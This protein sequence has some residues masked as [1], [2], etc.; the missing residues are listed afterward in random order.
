VK[1]NPDKSTGE[2]ARNVSERESIVPPL[3]RWQ[4][5]I[6]K[7][8][9]SML[10]VEY[11]RLEDYPQLLSAFQRI[12]TSLND[13]RTDLNL[14]PLTFSTSDVRLIPSE[15]FNAHHY[16]S[17]YGENG[18]FFDP[19][20]GVCYVRF[21]REVL[22][23]RR[24]EI[25]LMYVVAHELSHKAMKG[26]V[27][28]YSFHLDEGIADT[29]ARHVM[30]TSIYPQFLTEADYQNRESFVSGFQ[31]SVEGFKPEPRDVILSLP[32]E[33]TLGYSRIPQMRLLHQMKTLKPDVYVLILRLAFEGRHADVETL[34]R[35]KFSN[36]LAD[37][38]GDDE[39]NASE[40]VEN[41]VQM[42]ID[43]TPIRD[44]NREVGL[45]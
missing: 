1:E 28:E 44:S 42:Q 34:I 45:P 15:I 24:G 36:E 19:V 20:S 14:E 3:D 29:T 22:T 35:E 30:E 11:I 4:I 12:S 18:A 26:G 32:N 43:P 10:A 41:L 31:S 23:S 2:Q 37:Q 27:G 13:V 7:E 5:L 6:R 39:V 40:L 38:L 9:E 25:S 8:M 16:L 33:S 21:D 17:K